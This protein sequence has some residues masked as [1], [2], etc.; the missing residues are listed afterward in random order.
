MQHIYTLILLARPYLQKIMF[1]IFVVI[2]SVTAL[3]PH[4]SA[5]QM[6]LLDV[7]KVQDE[8][9]TFPI[10]GDRN[11]PK[12]MR[13]VVTAYSS[14]PWQTDS[15][16]F[17][18]ADG[19]T[20]RDG[21]IAANFLPLGTRVKLPELYGDREFVVKDRMN[22]R[23]WHRADVWMPHRDVA[24]QFGVQYTTIEVY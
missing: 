23:Y 2:F 5:A 20:V 19:T 18:T 4:A 10:S 1:G 17:E 22:A 21:I 15:T 16:P 6:A 14:D 11:A 8:D 9:V 24:R 12:T 13:I 7:V 3:F